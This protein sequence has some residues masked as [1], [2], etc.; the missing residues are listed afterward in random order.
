MPGSP[1]FVGVLPCTVA[2]G[3]EHRTFGMVKD[4]VGGGTD[5]ALYE[6][7]AFGPHNCEAGSLGRVQ[8]GSGGGGIGEQLCFDG[9]SGH[10]AAGSTEG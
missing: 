6:S 3:N 2:P 9:G 10:Q 1:F 8:D 5:G 7:V 4:C